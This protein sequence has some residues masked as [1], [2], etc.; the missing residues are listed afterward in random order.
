[1][2]KAINRL[3]VKNS[4]IELQSVEISNFKSIQT[5]TLSF[6]GITVLLGSNSAGKSSLMQSIL[7]AAENCSPANN[8]GLSLNSALLNLGSGFEVQPRGL[9]FG[10]SMSIALDFKSKQT[11]G[12]SSSKIV[13]EAPFTDGKKLLG[14]LEVESVKLVEEREV[15]GVKRLA[16]I[17]A[18]MN[19]QRRANVDGSQVEIVG[20]IFSRPMNIRPT[21]SHL[22]TSDLGT[23]L[24]LISPHYH[25]E[26]I[27]KTS[28]LDGTAQTSQFDIFLPNPS[29]TNVYLKEKI[30]LSLLEFFIYNQ[31]EQKGNDYDHLQRSYE[32]RKILIHAS[33][34]F[35][36]N[37]G[38]LRGKVDS[39]GILAKLEVTDFSQ[40]I[41][42]F[43]DFF[44]STTSATATSLAAIKKNA[45]EFAK[46]LA[47]ESRKFSLTAISHVLLPITGDFLSRD[48]QAAL[49]LERNITNYL[50]KSISYLGPLR[51]HALT[52]QKNHPTLSSNAPLGA[53]G[54]HLAWVLNS[55]QALELRAYP[56]PKA[57]DSDESEER[58]LNL[59][60]ALSSWI[61][62]FEV[63]ESV[64]PHDQ[65]FWGT[66]IQVDAENL[67]Q[68]GTG[69]S[70]ILPVLA[71][72]LMAD[73]GS[74]TMLEQPELHLHPRLQQK[75]GTFFAAMVRCGKKLLIETHSEYILTRIRREVAV[76]NLDKAAL[77]L[78][79]VSQSF[80]SESKRKVSKYEAV[81]VL[82][83]G[84]VAKWPD[85]YFDFT[86]ED[87]MEIFEAAM[88]ED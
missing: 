81:S 44:A 65:G 42:D 54:E 23:D 22:R 27:L 9:D 52:E 50:K 77:N 73:K 60:D 63:G 40:N 19:R 71:L 64:Q 43:S 58:K 46:F 34:E 31:V 47:Q 30:Y 75:L 80:A 13:L 36:K 59:K 74:L 2:G 29:N 87:K 18:R 49:F 24:P 35:Q 69:V 32:A 4:S 51:A 12:S 68:K 10:E 66:S 8:F 78:V 25:A 84:L 33:D 41:L 70:Q 39:W 79:F 83:S 55:A 26:F 28:S 48:Y 62:W 56:V 82:D 72:C 21:L 76:K 85:E 61:Q 15:N 53:K 6:P 67:N 17:K 5:C 20:T 86:A 1:M 57:K 14:V 7:L 38:K 11:Q 37:E 45:V 88:N 16:S 3:R